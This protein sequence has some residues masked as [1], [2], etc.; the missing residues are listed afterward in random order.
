M[1]W[2]HGWE[3]LFTREDEHLWRIRNIAYELLQLVTVEGA[4]MQAHRLQGAV[5][6]WRRSE[7]L[8]EG[9]WSSPTK[10]PLTLSVYQN[11]REIP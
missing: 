6:E 9:G 11:P 3:P 2:R 8:S 1:T 5:D 4:Q 10:L 7:S